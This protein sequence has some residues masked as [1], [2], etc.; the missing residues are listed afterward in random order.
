MR[1]KKPKPENTLSAFD[2][3]LHLLG[4]RAHFRRELERK[5]RQR[6]YPVPEIEAALDK[7]T[8]QG[9]LDDGRTAELFVESKLRRGGVGDRKLRAA[10]AARG[11]S[12]EVTREAAAS[13]SPEDQLEQARLATRRWLR[14]RDLDPVADRAALGRFLERRGF[15]T[16]QILAVLR[17]AGDAEPLED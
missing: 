6:S 12:A 17:D 8:A 14:G 13:V 5:L 4:S 16:S 10:L 2:K 15:S 3:A 1:E 9:L 11:A 7:L